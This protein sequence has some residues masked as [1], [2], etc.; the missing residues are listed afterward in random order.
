MTKQQLKLMA[1]IPAFPQA[2]QAK[3][4]IRERRLT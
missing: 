2:A 4:R 3:H 1:S